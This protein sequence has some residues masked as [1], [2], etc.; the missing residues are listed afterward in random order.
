M[1]G[2]TFAFHDNTLPSLSSTDWG[3]KPDIEITMM[4]LRRIDVF[5]CW[6]AGFTTPGQYYPAVRQPGFGNVTGA[7]KVTF[8]TLGYNNASTTTN[9]A[10]YAGSVYVGDSEPAYT[11]NNN[12]TMTITLTDYPPGQSNSCPTTPILDS[13]SHYLVSG[14]DYFNGTAKPGYTPYTYPHPLTLGSSGSGTPP[15]S[16]TSLSAIVN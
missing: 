8:P 13:A 15:A 10:G 12:R 16:P 14:R 6:G 3:T 4:T 2:G 11:W 5:P 1:R 9:P 7:G